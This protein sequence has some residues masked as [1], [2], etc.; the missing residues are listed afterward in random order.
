[1]Y[2]T[3]LHLYGYGPATRVPIGIL[4]NFCNSVSS[5]EGRGSLRPPRYRHLI[6][7]N[8]CISEKLV[9]ARTHNAKILPALIQPLLITSENLRTVYTHTLPPVAATN[10]EWNA[11]YSAS[12]RIMT[13]R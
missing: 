7:N 3:Y 9:L 1:M 11:R 6:H 2:H 12:M 4:A 13:M 10:S 5:S 8:S